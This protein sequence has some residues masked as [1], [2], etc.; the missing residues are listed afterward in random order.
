M[1]DEITFSYPKTMPAP[2]Y[3]HLADLETVTARWY[4]VRKRVWIGGTDRGQV[5]TAIW[6]MQSERQRHPETEWTVMLVDPSGASAEVYVADRL[7]QSAP[8]GRAPET[9]LRVTLPPL[10]MKLREMMESAD[11]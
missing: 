9:L 6:C 4:H 1:P 5:L 7:V 3:E 2:P 11:A 8:I 10:W